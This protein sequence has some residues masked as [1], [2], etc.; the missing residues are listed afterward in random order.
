M[1]RVPISIARVNAVAGN[2]RGSNHSGSAPLAPTTQ[3]LTMAKVHVVAQ[4]DFLESL[5]AARPIA[6]VAELV[7]NGF[8]AQSNRVQVSLDMNAMA[9]LQTIRVRDQG[10]GIF[11]PHVDELFGKLGDS[12]KKSKGRLNGRALHG[13]GGKGRFKAFALGRLVE[14]NTTYRDNGKTFTYKISGST[15]ALDDFEISDPV[16]SKATA[17]GT[18]VIVSN[19]RHEFTSLL[20]EKAPQEMAEMFAAY[21][22]EYPGLVLDYN[23][24]VV[25][26]KIAQDFRGDYHL[27]DVEIGEGR[28]VAVAVS[29]VEWNIP[30]DRVV[31]LC[32]ANGI[33]LYQTQAGQQIRAPGFNFTAYVKSD[34]FRELDKHNLLILDDLHPDVTEIVR[35]AKNKIKEH[36]RRRLAEDQT[37]IV[38]RWKQEQIYPYTDKPDLDPVEEAERQVFDILAANVQSYLPAFEEADAKSRRLTFLLLAQAIRDNPESVRRIF[39]EVLGLKKEDQDALAELLN[40]TSLTAIISAAQIV[41]NR[42]NF[43]R[44]LRSL[45]FDDGNKESLLER[46]Q[47]HRILENE[48]WIF[49]EEY[50]L[51]GSEDWLEEVLKKHI[52][53][54]G[55]RDDDDG[56]PVLREDGRRGRVDLML[57]RIVPQPRADLRRYLIVELKRPSVTVSTVEIGQVAS[58]ARTVA[59]DERFDQG[60]STWDF[61]LA[62]NAMNDDAYEACH[63][64]GMPDGVAWRSKDGRI[65]VWVKKWAEIIEEASA[66]LAFFRERLKYDANLDSA[67]AYLNKAHAK[68]LPNHDRAS[69]E[70]DEP[71]ASDVVNSEKP[72]APSSNSIAEGVREH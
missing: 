72:V 70:L 40:K 52:A 32:D 71:V 61:V 45:L 56:P 33:S 67:K 42:L 66:R 19:L 20:D 3:P 36:F 2:P 23:G 10:S 63:Q 26:P 69:D 8:D 58:Y 57:G 25:D 31:H 51:T 28:K 7:W 9:G 46:D 65:T 49:G 55:T 6:A 4:R 60:K 44:G 29:V 1:T 64:A 38:E 15:Q 62:T 39:E 16:E 50:N 30:T 47:L 5:T 11:H 13:K 41:A 43:V 27:G 34:H 35:I 48:T 24:V 14:W 18:E 54:L 59:R 68:F 12:W 37:K 53:L 22:T 21:L 17:V